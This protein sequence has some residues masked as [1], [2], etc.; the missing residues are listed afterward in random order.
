MINSP[1]IPASSSEGTHLVVRAGLNFKSIE[2]VNEELEIK[3]LK[4]A[5]VL[6]WSD[7][8]YENRSEIDELKENRLK[9]LANIS[10]QHSERGL[11]KSLNFDLVPGD[12]SNSNKFIESLMMN[13]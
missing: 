6:D 10:A 12:H 7:S 9:F 5:G 4:K 3:I 8:D 13:F 2:K 11:N 1:G